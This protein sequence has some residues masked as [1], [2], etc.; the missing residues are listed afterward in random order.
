MKI[1]KKFDRARLNRSCL[2]KEAKS[3]DSIRAPLGFDAV[4]VEVVVGEQAHGQNFRGGAVGSGFWRGEL[5]G[6]GDE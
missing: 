2:T 6:L 4:G 1:G 3:A 5:H